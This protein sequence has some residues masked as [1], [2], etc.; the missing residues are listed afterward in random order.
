ML[1]GLEGRMVI[2]EAG[3]DMGCLERYLPEIKKRAAEG[4]WKMQQNMRDV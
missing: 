3:K 1:G 4:E 2:P